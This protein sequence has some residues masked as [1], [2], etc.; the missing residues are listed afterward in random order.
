MKKFIL[1]L[2]AVLCLVSC[3]KFNKEYFPVNEI[4]SIDNGTFVNDN[5]VKYHITNISDLSSL[6]NQ[7]RIFVEG[8]A[9]FPEDASLGYDYELEISTYYEVKIQD[10]VKAS[11]SEEGFGDSPVAVMLGW[12]ANG[13]IN[14]RTIVSYQKAAGYHGSINLVFDDAK[15]TD[16]ELFFKLVN[17]QDGETWEDPEMTE[18]DIEFGASYYSFKYLSLIP[19]SVKGTVK[20][21]L[22]WN[23]F[24]DNP[25]AGASV[26]AHTVSE[27]SDTCE[28]TLE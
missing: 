27:K 15:S 19:E 16:S 21:T 1:L 5:G 6:K 7:K 3:D 24:D 2:A 13:Y 25:I 11:S 12:F 4:I 26:P 8:R 22:T 14:L 18:G 20:V 17:A 23:W 10:A 9:C 28:I